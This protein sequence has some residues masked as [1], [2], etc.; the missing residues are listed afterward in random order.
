MSVRKTAVLCCVCLLLAVGAVAV[1]FPFGVFSPP[2]SYDY[3]EEQFTGSQD[4]QAYLQLEGVDPD[5]LPA[6]P[7]HHYD[8]AVKRL[9]IDTGSFY[10]AVR[11][12]TLRYLLQSTTSYDWVF[13]RS[14]HGS[15]E[16][17]YLLRCHNGVYSVPDP[18][19]PPF[20]GY[21]FLHSPD[22]LQQTLNQAGLDHPDF[23]AYFG[24]TI[25]YSDN[26]IYAEQDGIPYIIK[27]SYYPNRSK[28]E[29]ESGEFF[30]YENFQKSVAE[31]C[32]IYL[33]E[34][35]FEPVAMGYLPYPDWYLNY[36]NGV[37][38]LAQII[39]WVYPVS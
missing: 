14:Y 9:T 2:P 38:T 28:E 37:Y 7:V 20:N 3:R 31:K 24:F 16:D 33:Y 26:Y 6:F 13:Q 22:K 18:Q 15:D 17:Y 25:T 32:R 23:I 27:F 36:F 5:N 10:R 29:K 30:P 21:L 4:W 35:Y 19:K 11:E 34:S 1:L 39:D 8:Q 12:G